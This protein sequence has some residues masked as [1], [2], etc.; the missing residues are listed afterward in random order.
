MLSC[1]TERI[2]MNYFKKQ[3][4]IACVSIAVGS[5]VSAMPVHWAILGL[6]PVHDFDELP[7][8]KMKKIIKD[9]KDACKLQLDIVSKASDKMLEKMDQESRVEKSFKRSALQL[10]SSAPALRGFSPLISPRRSSSGKNGDE[11]RKD[12]S[13][14]IIKATKFILKMLSVDEVDT[15]KFIEE[16]DSVVLVQELTQSD[17]FKNNSNVYDGDDSDDEFGFFL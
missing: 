1:Q 14:R 5:I 16:V 2:L 9:V 11:L 6:K 15:V 4:I 3:L 10:S 13:E 7:S 12:L 8:K 17:S